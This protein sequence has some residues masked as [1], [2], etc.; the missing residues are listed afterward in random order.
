MKKSTFWQLF[1]EQNHRFFSFNLNNIHRIFFLQ[2]IY[3]VNQSYS[4]NYNKFKKLKT[5]KKKKSPLLLDEL[6]ALYS[7]EEEVVF[8]TRSFEVPAMIW[9]ES[10]EVLVVEGQYLELGFLFAR[11]SL[12]VL[13]VE[14]QYLELVFLLRRESLEVLVV[15][16]RYLE[17]V[18]LIRRESLDLVFFLWT[19]FL[20]LVGDSVWMFERK[21]LFSL[22]LLFEMR[23]LLATPERRLL[24]FSCL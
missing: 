3:T 19:E 22:F 23:S 24:G 8:E 10:L 14:T 5:F 18:F 20:E 16:T 6:V 21:Y 7:M 11:E 13:V 1:L 2:Q 9:R 4:K 17:L 12:E 15:E